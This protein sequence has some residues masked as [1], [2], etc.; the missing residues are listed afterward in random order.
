VI[1]RRDFCRAA[2]GTA[3]VAPFIAPSR[4]FG[5]MRLAK[6]HTA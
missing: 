2:I 5:A 4:L 1:L 3:A 6:A